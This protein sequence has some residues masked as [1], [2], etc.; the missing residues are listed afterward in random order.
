MEITTTIIQILVPA[1]ILNVWLVRATRATEYRGGQARTLKEEFATYGL[2]EP[3]FYLVGALKITSSLAILAGFVVPPLLALGAAMLAFL[4]AG[5]LAMHLKVGDPPK[6]SIPASTL[7]V[8]SL[9]L[10]FAA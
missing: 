5:A 7:L 6:K 1:I 2:P 10:V 4:M 8:L 3:A 9:W